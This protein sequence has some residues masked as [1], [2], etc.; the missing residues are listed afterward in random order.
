VQRF[1]RVVLERSSVQL[2]GGHDEGR[3][4]GDGV[5]VSGVKRGSKR[6]SR[7]EG[8]WG[9][10]ARYTAY[11]MASRTSDGY[12]R[13]MSDWEGWGG[14]TMSETGGEG[15]EGEI[16]RWLEGVERVAGCGLRVEGRDGGMMM[17][18]MTGMGSSIP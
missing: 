11:V 13:N 5:G 16:Y 18:K 17:S 6:G 14:K 7:E 12:S 1:L 3:H 15:S 2:G 10:A 8:N 4:V 9:S